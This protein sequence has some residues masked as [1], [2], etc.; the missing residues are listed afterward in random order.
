MQ[1]QLHAAVNSSRSN[2]SQQSSS[3]SSSNSSSNCLRII[4]MN[5]SGYKLKNILTTSA[6]T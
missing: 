5:K 6:Y 2:R 3:S 1:Q 4:L